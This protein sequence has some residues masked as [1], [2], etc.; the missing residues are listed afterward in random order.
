[1]GE[2][3]GHGESPKI[4]ALVTSGRYRLTEKIKP[5]QLVS[6]RAGP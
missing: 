2:R 6:L 1:M 4:C 3:E 5:Y